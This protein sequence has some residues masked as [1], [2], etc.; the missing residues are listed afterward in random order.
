KWSHVSKAKLPLYK[1]LID[2]FFSSDLEF[3]SVLV[4]YKDKLDHSQFNQGSHD[5]F[6]YK[7][8]Y[9]LLYNPLTTVANKKYAVY[10]DI[11]DTKSK[12]KLIKLEEVFN[13]KFLGQSP[14]K[15]FQ[16][17][18]S[19]ESVFL[20]LAD[21]FIGAI[22]YK[23]RNLCKS[24]GNSSAKNSFIDYLELKSGYSLDEGTEPWEK[25]FNIFDHQ[26]KSRL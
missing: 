15:H 19:A 20:Q 13:N 9:F 12:S 24:K 2:Y 6:Y 26:P 21:L 11:K 5:N 17:I 14:F 10:L 1:S 8:I 18:N 7:L 4:K 16:S 22:T 3:R 25:K 23:A